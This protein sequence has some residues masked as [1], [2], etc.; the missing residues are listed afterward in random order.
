MWFISGQFDSNKRHWT[1]TIALDQ[2]TV[3]NTGL[4]VIRYDEASFMEGFTNCT[5]ISSLRI[6]MKCIQGNVAT[7]CKIL[8]W[9]FHCKCCWTIKRRQLGIVVQVISAD[10]KFQFS[11]QCRLLVRYSIEETHI[12]VEKALSATCAISQ[13]FDSSLRE[14]K[15]AL[16]GL[17]RQ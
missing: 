1:R 3:A 5:I 10:T 13:P 6:R 11:I 17:S 16:S 14:I 2:W 4:S 7:L 12:T 15:Q 8:Q 9:F